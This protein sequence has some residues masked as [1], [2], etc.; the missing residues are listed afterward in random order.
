MSEARVEKVP[1]KKMRHSETR[2]RIYELLCASDMHPSA[3]MIYYALKN[4]NPSL[5]LGTVYRN[6]RQL[7]EMGL[8][9]RVTSVNDKERYDA[10]TMDHV[11]FVCSECERVIDLHPAD[12]ESIMKSCAHF[13]GV[14]AE[15][16]SIVLGGVCQNCTTK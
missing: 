10:N 15:R 11:H 14:R 2:D 1:D 5:S 7:E 16:I 12:I 3:E 13:Y 9:T 4:E 6:L 8:V